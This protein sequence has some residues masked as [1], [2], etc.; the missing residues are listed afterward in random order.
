MGKRKVTILDTAVEAV[1]K[2]SLFIEGKGL[3]ETAKRFVDEVFLFFD[4]LSDERL[5]HRACQHTPWKKL[6]YRCAT[7]RKK[8]T[9]A[10]LE[11]ST[12]IVICE[13]VPTKLLV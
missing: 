1:A 6:T 7:F 10:Y 2:V 4:K 8:Y 12:E 13:F 5:V 3:P 11:H 9:V